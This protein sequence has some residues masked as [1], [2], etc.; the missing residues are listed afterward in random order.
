MTI[1][2]IHYQPKKQAETV[3]TLTHTRYLNSPNIV[4][5]IPISQED[6]EALRDQATP[7]KVTA[8]P[9]FQPKDQSVSV[10]GES[11]SFTEA[12]AFDKH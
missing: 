9:E 4:R 1:A 11:K 8:E 3:L 7:T 6:R 12:R 2:N 5:G 10:L